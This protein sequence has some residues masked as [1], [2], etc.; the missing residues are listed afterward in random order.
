MKMTTQIIDNRT[1][2]NFKT[3]NWWG[4]VFFNDETNF[5]LEFNTKREAVWFIN[6]G[7][8]EFNF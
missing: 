6:G 1:R 4:F 5:G 2:Q 3:G 7:Y 8:K